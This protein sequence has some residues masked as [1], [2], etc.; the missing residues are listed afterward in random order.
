METKAILP[1]TGAFVLG[2]FVGMILFV[3]LFLPHYTKAINCNHWADEV[4]NECIDQYPDFYDT[5]GEGDSWDNY[6]SNK[7]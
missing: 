4:I 7:Q 2:L 1:A 5:I 6:I 3:L